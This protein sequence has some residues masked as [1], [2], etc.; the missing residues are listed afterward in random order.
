MT[1]LHLAA[2]EGNVDEAE[3]LTEA[4]ANLEAK[5]DFHDTPLRS[6]VRW[7]QAMTVQRLLFLR[8]DMEARDDSK[9]TAMHIAA[10]KER[11][12]CLTA[13]VDARGDLQVRDENE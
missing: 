12:D 4:R 1:A 13:L 6:A 8:S 10:S 11:L 9:V 2:A 3:V 5:D 7:S